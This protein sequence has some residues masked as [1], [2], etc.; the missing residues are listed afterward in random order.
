MP[1]DRVTMT[2]AARALLADIVAEHGPVMFVQSGG[3]CDGS[4]PMCFKEGDYII[5]ARDINLGEVEGAPVWISESLFEIWKHSQMILDAG[6]GNGAG[7]SLDTGRGTCFLSRARVF[8]DE[9]WA[10]FEAVEA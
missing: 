2:D 9:E 5:G 1:I 4:S 8:T 7:F 3:C 6:P 10:E